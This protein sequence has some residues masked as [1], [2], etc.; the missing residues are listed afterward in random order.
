M[1][2]ASGAREGVKGF[3]GGCR[4]RWD[5]SEGLRLWVEGLRAREIADKLSVS[6]RAIT[7]AANRYEW[8][9]RIKPKG[10]KAEST[11]TRRCPDCLG[12]YIKSHQ[13]FRPYGLR[14]VTFGW[15]A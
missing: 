11:P 1:S 6:E 3:Q 2:A 15:A 10:A 14:M 8:P 12:V 13:C 5:V 7:S 9:V 4:I